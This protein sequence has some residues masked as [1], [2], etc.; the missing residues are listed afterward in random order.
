MKVSKPSA[1]IAGISGQDGAHLADHLL[2][3][4]YKVYGGFRSSSNNK[5]WRTDFLGITDKID[6]FE[7]HLENFQCIMDVFKKIQPDEIYNLAGESFVSDSFHRPNHTIEINTQGTLNILEAAKL[8]SPDSNIFIASSSEIFGQNRDGGSVNEKSTKNPSNPYAISKLS[9]DYFVK[10]YREQFGLFVCS[11]I[12]FN[13]E[14]PLRSQHFVTRKISH[15]MAR[16][17]LGNLE[18]F[19]LGGF[20]S[21]R[22]WGAAGDYVKAMHLMLKSEQPNDYVIATGKLT[23]IRQVVEI[24][25]NFVGFDPVFKGVGDKEIC[26]DRKSGNILVSISSDYYRPFDTTPLIGD[27]AHIKEAL[28]WRP[29]KTIEQIMHSM[30]EADLYRIEQKIAYI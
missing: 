3:L 25:A 15:N 14:G 22:D 6:F 18:S 11:G 2:K 9:A 28:G 21:A 27:A 20:D 17:K 13:H 7:F 10:L 29:K 4:G 16:L 23:T 12:L 19:K 1:F 30:I 24:C 8:S 5:T 26:I